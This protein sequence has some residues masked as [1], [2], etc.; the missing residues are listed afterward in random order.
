MTRLFDR[1]IELHIF[2]ASGRAEV[3]KEHD[4]SVDV[5]LVR[6][7]DPNVATIEIWGL[8]AGQRAAFAACKY[9]EIHAGYAD[10][11]G[12]IFRGSWDPALSIARHYKDGPDWRTE[13][14]TSDG[15][16][17]FQTS[18]L[19]RAY[20]A[21][22]SLERILKDLARQMGLPIVIELARGYHLTQPAT[23]SGRVSALFDD[24]AW[25]HKFDWA[26]QNGGIIV[27]EKAEPAQSA[28]VVAYLSPQT[29]MVG[30]P[31][32]DAEGVTIQTMMLPGLKPGGLVQVE[33]PDLDVLIRQAWTAGA[34]VSSSGGA[35]GL[36]KNLRK[37][38]ANSTHGVFIIDSVSY[39]GDNFGGDFGAE[40]VALYE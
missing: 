33:A 5:E 29:G 12:L 37:Y 16:K 30:A 21:G 40:V 1:K 8:S 32:V 25:A 14:E 19:D 6:T 17:E 18:F 35:G 23:L 24:L 20:P 39:F 27:T 10:E 36:E 13:I 4:M 15:A 2:D 11:V 22:T 9:L 7:S 28:G 34:A 26:I 38:H 31:A 3:F